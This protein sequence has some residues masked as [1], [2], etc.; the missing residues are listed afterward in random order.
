MKQ[1][2]L[3]KTKI[4][5]QKTKFNSKGYDNDI[6]DNVVKSYINLN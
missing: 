3:L 2:D 1:L 4:V 5:G 6:A